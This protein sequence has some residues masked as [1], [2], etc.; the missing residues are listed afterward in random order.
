MNRHERNET[1]AVFWCAL[2][3][4]VLFGD[5]SPQETPRFLR[6]LSRAPRRFPDGTTRRPSLSTL[7]RKLQGFRRG[8]I[9]ALYRR[10]RGDR[11][12]PRAHDPAVIARAIAI[13]RDQP[14]RSEET[15]NR[16]LAAES[17]A[18]IPRSSLYRY[19]HR[20][21]A[22]KRKLDL[23]N[24]PVRK[25]FTRDRTHDLWVGDFEHG[26]Y[27]LEDGRPVPT[28]LSAF[29]DCHSRF[30]VEGRYYLRES[31]DVL[32]D[33]L[34]RALVVH[35]AP[36]A[37]FVDNAKVYHARQL[38]AACYALHIR[39]FHRRARDPATGGLIERFFQTAQTQFEAEVR[40]ADILTLEQ[41]NRAFQAW[42][43]VSYHGRPNRETGEPPRH[44]LEAGRAEPRPVD[45]A[46]ALRF[47]LQHETRRVHRDFADVQLG[48]RFFR[49]DRRLRGDRVEV[50][51]DPFTEPL[52]T[53]FLYRSD[54]VYL[55]QGTRHERRAGE[56]A[57]PPP[58]PKPKERYLELLIVEHERDLARRSRGIDFPRAMAARRWPLNAF[59]TTLAELWGRKGGLSAFSTAELEALEKV[60]RRHPTL[61]RAVVV[62]AFARTPD[63]SLPAVVRE[64]HRSLYPRKERP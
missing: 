16:F 4:P 50:R 58:R 56:R 10:P 40:A 46:R 6:Q 22:T 8:G 38:Q 31:L 25:R 24:T 61:Q 53:V 19:L 43:A 1:W 60:Y 34:L 27:V 12:K 57:A 54:G 11:G 20:A 52:D 59:L 17:K 63:K 14:G 2:L 55:G 45:M 15:I 49:V 7:K 32:I 42:L 48:G 13:K 3:E 51:Y 28:R 23:V 9:E 33:S 5:V 21:G 62:D 26:P 36:R 18:P 30:L 39:L 41:L 29:I 44:R 47:F 37:I 35:G 64:I